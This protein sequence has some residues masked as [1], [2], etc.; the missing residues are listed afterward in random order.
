M[1][2]LRI[3]VSFDLENDRDLHDRLREDSDRGSFDVVSRSEAGEPGEAWMARARSRIS[4]CDEVVV[5]CGEYTDASAGVS[6]E[7]A[8]AQ[9]EEKPCVLRWGRREAMCKKPKA[10]RHDDSIYSWTPAVLEQQMASAMRRSREPEIPASMKRQAP[11][12][13]VQGS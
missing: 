5:I 12:R 8:I 7:L 2:D 6:L 9:E 10:A 1:P 4:G 11:E 13:R 3:H